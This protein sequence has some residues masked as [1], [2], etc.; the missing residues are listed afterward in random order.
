LS[1][2]SSTITG[3]VFALDQRLRDAAGSRVV[4]LRRCAGQ[5]PARRQRVHRHELVA[6]AERVREALREVGLAQARLA[7]QQDRQELDGL[8]AGDRERERLAQ[9]VDDVVKLG[10]SRRGR[11]PRSSSKA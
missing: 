7:E 5:H 2:S 9:V 6:G 1:I 11:R 3:F 10:E 4:P 8:V